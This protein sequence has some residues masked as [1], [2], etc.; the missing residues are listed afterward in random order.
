MRILLAFDKFKD[1]ITAPTACTL[2]A[3]VLQELHP[4]W[5]IDLAPLTDGGEGFSEI[6]TRSAHGQL[7]SCTANGPRGDPIDASFGLVPLSSVPAPA[8]AQLALPDSTP[9]NAPIAIVEMAAAS[10]LAL[11]APSQRDPWQTTSLGTGQLMLAAARRS[12]AAILL[13]VGG[14][15]TND[16]GL[17][18]LA[19][20]GLSFETSSRLRLAPPSPATWN[21]LTHLAG[22]IDPTLPPICIACDV[23]N[24]LLGPNGCTATFGPQKGLLIADVPHLEAASARV[25]NLLLQHHAQPTTL[26]E[27]PGAGAAGGIAFGLMCAAH[28]KLLPGFSLVSAWLDLDARIAA[29]DIVLTGEGRF[30]ATS[31]GGKGPGAVVTRARALGKRVHVFA[32]AIPPELARSDPSLHAISPPELPLSD[33]L[34]STSALLA[35]AI[36]TTRLL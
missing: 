1:A 33:A 12:A 9:R 10:G 14:S 6:L 13:G 16:L 29:A 19:A 27:T 34:R 7:H 18:A 25:A 21:D 15:A 5:Q 2:A 23:T 36:R 31:L 26:L 4:D 20:L 35:R 24:P 32:G 22:R 17:G 28:A 8:R 3:E 30:D 11:L